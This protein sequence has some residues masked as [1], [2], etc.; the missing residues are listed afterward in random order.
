M[1][2]D[3]NL[4]TRSA[5]GIHIAIVYKGEAKGATQMAAAFVKAGAGK[6]KGLAVSATAVEFETVSDLLSRFEKDGINGL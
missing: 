6:V 4:P 2:F 1:A 5:N 3:R